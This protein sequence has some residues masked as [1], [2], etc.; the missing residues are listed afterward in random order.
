[1]IDWTTIKCTCEGF[2]DMTCLAC[3]YSKN[4]SEVDKAYLK[5]YSRMIEGWDGERKLTAD[6]LALVKYCANRNLHLA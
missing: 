1:M 2:D 5:A 4:K 3:I 6:E